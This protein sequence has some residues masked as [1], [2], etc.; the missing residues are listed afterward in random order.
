MRL[1]RQLDVNYGEMRWF[2]EGLFGD[3]SFERTQR[4]LAVWRMNLCDECSFRMPRGCG[5][6]GD[7]TALGREPGS[8]ILKLLRVID[9]MCP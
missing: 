6:D 3:V 9:E 7:C 4:K 8:L 2:C 5:S 1:A